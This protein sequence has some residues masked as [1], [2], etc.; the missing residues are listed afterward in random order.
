MTSVY[1]SSSSS[2][3]A[4]SNCVIDVETAY[5][6]ILDNS[7]HLPFFVG[8]G[9]SYPEVPLA[10]EIVQKL[11]HERIYNRHI[12]KGVWKKRFPDDKEA[13]FEFWKNDNKW[14]ESKDS[15]SRAMLEAF[16]DDPDDVAVINQ[17]F[18]DHILSNAI[19][20]FSH[21]ALALLMKYNFI[22]KTCITTN[23]DRLIE[24]AF[25]RIEGCDAIPIR[26]A[27]EIDIWDHERHYIIK[28]HG[29]GHFYNMK[30][31]QKQ[32]TDWDEKFKK[33]ILGFRQHFSGLVIIGLG[34][35]ENSIKD[36][37]KAYM[38]SYMTQYANPSHHRGV[39]W[40]IRTKRPLIFDRDK[41]SKERD[42]FI[43]CIESEV[44][45]DIIEI[46]KDASSKRTPRIPFYFFPLANS[47]HFFFH[48]VQKIGDNTS[49]SS[50]K[51]ALIEKFSSEILRFYGGD[52]WVYS[53]IRK[54]KDK[55]RLTEDESDKYR[56]KLDKANE[57]IKSQRNKPLRSVTQFSTLNYLNSRVALIEGD[58]SICESDVIVSS[59]D[60]LL[61]MNDGVA[62]AIRTAGGGQII[63]DVQKFESELPLESPE[64]I[65]T[66]AGKLKA[67][68]SFH[69]AI[70][71][72]RSSNQNFN[73]LVRKAVEKCLVLM[74]T[75]SCRSITFPLLASGT[76]GTSNFGPKESAECIFDTI[77]SF[78]VAQPSGGL[79][80]AV[81]V[82]GESTIRDNNLEALLNECFV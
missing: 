79:E 6:K 72:P 45:S 17:Y 67:K 14:L 33:L 18:Q 7:P 62:G 20:N 4:S 51:K 15:Y 65:V 27:P 16:G 71:D 29:D 55:L 60:I 77:K 76:A 46:F 34:G 10:F 31:T 38:E 41:P 24:M 42:E 80:I 48:L 23:F 40:G 47:R 39:L 61:M 8:A 28:V 50:T 13:D 37:F 74:K 58:I 44:N 32:T 82:Y 43:S 30:Q 81:C 1:T 52:E 73:L 49:V 54:A 56:E 9:I 64:V 21:Y 35:H 26:T 36:F 22:N 19:P 2:S 66:N 5:Q 25:M 59:D 68:Y 78:L 63:Q 3:L 75:M 53:S 57:R 70:L 12:S 69:S 11:A